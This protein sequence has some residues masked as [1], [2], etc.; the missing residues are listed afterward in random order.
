MLFAGVA[1]GVPAGEAEAGCFYST[2]SLNRE[3]Q[4]ELSAMLL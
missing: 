2:A 3:E 1:A 4:L